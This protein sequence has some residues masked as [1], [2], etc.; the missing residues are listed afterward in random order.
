M[1]SSNNFKY[2]HSILFII[3]ITVFSSVFNLPNSIY[4]YNLSYLNIIVT[5][6]FLVCWFLFGLFN[7]RRKNFISIIFTISY[8]GLVMI[9]YI[10][11]ISTIYSNDFK[12]FRIYSWK[13]VFCKIINIC[14]SLTPFCFIVIVV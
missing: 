4:S 7:G 14:S 2:K 10:Y 5:I 1:L 6:L 11:F 12:Y 9:S 3:I 13:D 8:L